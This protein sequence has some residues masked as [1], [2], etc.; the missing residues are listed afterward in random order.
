MRK[1][2]ASPAVKRSKFCWRD[3]AAC[4]IGPHRG[5]A[6]LKICRGLPDRG[7]RHQG[8]AGG[9]V[10]AAPGRR[11]A[12]RAGRGCGAGADFWP[13]KMIAEKVRNSV[14]GGLSTGLADKGGLAG[15][16]QRRRDYDRAG[17]IG[18]RSF[19]QTHA[20]SVRRFS[21]RF[22][23]PCHGFQQ[24][25]KGGI[26]LSPPPGARGGE[27]AQARHPAPYIRLCSGLQTGYQRAIKALSCYRKS[28]ISKA[29]DI[30]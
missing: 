17:P 13:E 4:G 28:L 3:V 8:M 15:T 16:Q 24:L 19:S 2:G 23:R 7:C 30:P 9:A 25:N 29:S 1:S 6:I 14:A 5:D 21:P 18:H 12:V 22:R 10:L 27:K 11:T 20:V 26:S